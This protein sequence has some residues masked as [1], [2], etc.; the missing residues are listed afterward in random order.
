MLIVEQADAAG[1]PTYLE[2][3]AAC[4]VPYYEKFGFDYIKEAH[5]QRGEKPISLNIMV[6]E[7][8]TSAG[9]SLPESTPNGG[10]KLEKHVV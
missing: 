5:L 10:V 6:R 4:N 1:A 7:P 3:S 8:Q 2:S 9:A